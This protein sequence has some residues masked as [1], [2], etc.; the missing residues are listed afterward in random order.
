MALCWSTPADAA[1]AAQAFGRSLALLAH[2][3]EC[4]EAARA[5]AGTG[6]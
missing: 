2:V 6:A 5:A 1:L 3:E 4:R